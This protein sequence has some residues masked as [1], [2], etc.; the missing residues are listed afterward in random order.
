MEY[1]WTATAGEPQTEHINFAGLQNNFSTQAFR[2]TLKPA[3]L[4][5]SLQLVISQR[6]TR[7]LKSTLNVGSVGNIPSA[8]LTWRARKVQGQDCFFNLRIVI[9]KV[10]L[11]LQ[12]C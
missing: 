5:R 7:Q 12:I 4:W 1:V 11:A 6:F 8:I 3:S 2:E 9:H 10:V